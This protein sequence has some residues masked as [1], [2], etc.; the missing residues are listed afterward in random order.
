[1]RGVAAEVTFS[2]EARSDLFSI[3]LWVEAAA[4]EAVAAAYHA[5]LR[6]ACLALANFPGR[7]TPRPDLGPDVRSI[8]FERRAVIAYLERPGTVEILAIAH[9]GRDLGQEMG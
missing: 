9:R 6:A 5:R 7:G 8:S 4:G 1:R 3:Y 2:G